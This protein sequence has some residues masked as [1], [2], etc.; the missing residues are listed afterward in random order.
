MTLTAYQEN[1]KALA[2]L[3]GID[4]ADAALQLKLRIAVNFDAAT[5]VSRTLGEHVIA[6]LSRTV[7]HAGVPSE[8]QYDVEIVIGPRESAVPAKA[9]VYASLSFF[10]KVISAAC[11]LS[12]GSSSWPTPPRR[13]G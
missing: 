1:A 11:R 5:S 12:R 2:A 10:P 8:G 9:R 6:L 3:L 13:T 7:E 4:E